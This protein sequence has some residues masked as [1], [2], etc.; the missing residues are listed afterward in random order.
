VPGD[1]PNAALI[2]EPRYDDCRELDAAEKGRRGADHGMMRAGEAE[3]AVR[4]AGKVG[5]VSR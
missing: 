3:N 1:Q 2:S 5:F 4:A